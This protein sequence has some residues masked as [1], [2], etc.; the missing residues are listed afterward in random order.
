MEDKY[1]FSGLESKWQRVWEETGIY[2]SDPHPVKPK[3]YALEM[4]PYPSG[5]LHMGHTRNY[6]IG[7]VI[8]RFRR[9]SG[10]C[11]L[12]PIGWDAFGLPAENAAI[13]RGIPPSDWTK[14]N[15]E[16]MREQFRRLGLS[17]DWR[18]EVASHHPG[19]YKWTQ[20]LFLRLFKHGLAYRKKAQVNWCPDCQ[21]V[22]ANEQVVQGLCERCSTEV[23]KRELKQ[24][25][26]RITD[27]ADR[28]LENLDN[29]E[30]WPEKVKIMQRN[31]IG[32]SE[33]IEAIFK[34]KGTN[35]EVKVFTT[36]HD[37]IFGVTYLV[38]APE[39]R[40]V[41]KII[42]GSPEEQE[43]REFIREVTGKSEIDR[44]SD[45]TEKTGVPTGAYAINPMSGETIPIWIG[46][47]VLPHYGTGAVMGVPAH[48]QRD[49]EF[50]KKY[51]LP[52][53]PVISPKTQTKVGEDK[54]YE[55]PGIMINSPGFNGTESEVA[56]DAIADFMEKRGLGN[57]ATNYRLRDWLISRQRY[58]GAPIPIVYCNSC[59]IVAIP[60]NELPVR[61]PLDVEFTPGGQ[62]PLN[63]IPEFVNTRCPKCNGPAKRETD[64]MDTFMC[65]SWYYI[66]FTCPRME[67]KAWDRETADYWLPVDQ[68]TG[69][70]EHAILHLMYS[71]F[72]TMFLHDIGLL[73]TEE[74]FARLLTQGMV[75]KDGIK[76]SKSKGNIVDLKEMLDT[77]GA[78]TVRLFTLFASPP[79]R[80]FEW[81][82]QGVEGASR[83]LGR[84]RRLIYEFQHEFN[85]SDTDYK[86]I[87]ELMP[88]DKEM[89]RKVHTTLEKVT[90]DLDRYSLNTVIAAVMELVNS[91]YQFREAAKARVSA[92]KVMKEAI[93]IVLLMLAPFVPHITE[94]LWHELGFTDSIHKEDWPD[95]DKSALFEAE[96]EIV[97]QVNGRV[98]DRMYAPK[99]KDHKYL[100]S[101][102]LKQDR[103]KE[104]VGNKEIRNVFVV[105]DKLVNIVI[106]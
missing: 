99:G 67:D 19:Y 71:R 32:K 15:I 52:I 3:Y 72:F 77:Y 86:D 5:R 41:G 40:L 37:T 80:D 96:V 103:I 74:P 46:N 79:D 64:T 9:M 100:E 20:W 1:D 18:R 95:I 35:D 48:D 54:V 38:L 83:F 2:H 98:R 58:W 60:E 4:F 39:H 78:D 85:H 8:A 105:P 75:L 17:Y 102:A 30:G 73:K 65:S 31:W 45:L 43:I 50:A 62:S 12:H 14:T 89:R 59:G 94:E 76:M 29:L 104:F 69:G 66:R 26:L 91:L 10:F 55:D 92:G 81:N 21:T 82:E 7:D 56:K 34:L 90:K 63:Y 36:R 93:E 11:V 68:Y 97:I 49:F 22:L 28:L 106:S 88:E 33:G 6:A 16:H 44:T 101:A 42:S 27:Y 51:G 23:K 61:L 57:R 84:V 87:P 53:K 25:F 70:V 47:Y 24:W 13:E